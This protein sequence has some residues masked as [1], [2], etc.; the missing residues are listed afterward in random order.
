MVI[1][2]LCH[3]L[4]NIKLHCRVTSYA[5]AEQKGNVLGNT[6]GVTVGCNGLYWPR[7]VLLS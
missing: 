6:W 3:H 2:Q 4:H 1:D 7:V 5:M